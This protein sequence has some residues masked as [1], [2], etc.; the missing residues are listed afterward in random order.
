MPEP[1]PKIQILHAN[2]DVK[3]RLL[4]TGKHEEDFWITAAHSAPQDNEGAGAA[5]PV[6]SSSSGTKIVA[7]W[8][9]NGSRCTDDKAS[10]FPKNFGEWNSSPHP[11]G[12]ENILDALTAVGVGGDEQ[13]G[14]LRGLSAVL[15]LGQVAR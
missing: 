11:G 12:L 2:E 1:N 5:P 3:K 6:D 4:L 10:S 7:A 9:S 15:H 13:D 8:A 14:L